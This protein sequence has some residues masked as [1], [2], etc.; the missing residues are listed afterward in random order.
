MLPRDASGPAAMSE[1]AHCYAYT[2]SSAPISS[3]SVSAAHTADV[4]MFTTRLHYLSA[5]V[6]TASL[7]VPTWPRGAHM[8]PLLL[9]A[10]NEHIMLAARRRRGCHGMLEVRTCWSIAPDQR[11]AAP[12]SSAA[13]PLQDGYLVLVLL[14]LTHDVQ[15][16]RCRA[17][18]ASVSAIFVIRTYVRIASRVCMCRTTSVERLKIEH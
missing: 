7:A 14:E 10:F 12:S 15:R 1:H 2:A 3:A 18:I 8:A 17:H 16:G 11:R 9:R 13:R 6:R 5:D 4:C